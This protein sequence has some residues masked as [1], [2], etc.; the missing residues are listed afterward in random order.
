MVGIGEENAGFPFL[1]W[2]I[3]NPSKLK[4][5]ADDNFK[6]EENGRNSSKWV[7]NIVG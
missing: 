5:F 1:I 3:S 4:D 7:E 6:L 2:Q